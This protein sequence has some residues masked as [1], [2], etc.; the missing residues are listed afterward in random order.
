MPG[1]VCVG[2][3]VECHGE[4]EYHSPRYLIV[5]SVDRHCGI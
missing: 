1:G 5:T 2:D 3:K 4:V